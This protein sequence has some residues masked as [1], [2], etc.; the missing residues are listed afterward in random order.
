MP[1]SSNGMRL[2]MRQLAEIHEKPVDCIALLPTD[3]LSTLRF[4]LDGPEGTPFKDGRFLVALQFDEQFPEV[5]PKGFFR[6]PIFHP[7]VAPGTGDICVNA[8]K[9]DWD[10]SLGLR[11]ILVVIRC[12]L[13]E[14]NAE[15]ALNEEAGRLLLEDYATYER[16]AAM[17]AGVH[18]KRAP[19]VP[20]HRGEEEQAASDAT[21]P[22]TASGHA[23]EGDEDGD[24]PSQFASGGLRSVDGNR[25]QVGMTAAERAKKRA[26][27][28]RKSALRRI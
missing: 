21:A 20:R 10:P 16:R 14:P 11:H 7:N 18:A 1:L 27:E 6:T 2:V 3:D 28:K 19:G 23:G 13:V 26:A 8:L 22:A 17:M 5:P 25:V 12:L 24:G 9:R 15:S 4:E